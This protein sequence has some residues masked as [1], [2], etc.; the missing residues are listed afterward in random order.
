MGAFRQRLVGDGGITLQMV[1]QQ[2][3]SGIKFELFHF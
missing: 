1:Q 3:V 2:Q